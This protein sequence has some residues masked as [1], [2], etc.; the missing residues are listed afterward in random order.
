MPDLNIEC[1]YALPEE[2]AL[3]SIQVSDGATVAEVLNLAEVRQRVPAAELARAT[4][5]IWGRV[6]DREQRIKSGD[7]VEIYRSLQMDPREARRQL[8]ANGLTMR[9]VHND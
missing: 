7:R 5:G 4:V 3:F 9:D 1:V 6:V 8:A 2:Q